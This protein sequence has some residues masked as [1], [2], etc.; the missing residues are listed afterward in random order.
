MLPK[1]IH[2]RKQVLT[3][4]F[5]RIPLRLNGENDSLYVYPNSFLNLS[6]DFSME[7]R[8]QWAFQNIYNKVL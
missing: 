4:F 1:V 3:L 8:V 6:I 7:T 5:S 2:V